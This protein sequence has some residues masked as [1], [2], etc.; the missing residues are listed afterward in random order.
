MSNFKSNLEEIDLQ[1]MY[2]PSSSTHITTFR[3]ILFQM[4]Q[5]N[6]TILT[7]LAKAALDNVSSLLE[8]GSVST[9]SL[10]DQVMASNMSLNETNGS[11]LGGPTNFIEELLQNTTAET[12]DTTIAWSWEDFGAGTRAPRS[13]ARVKTIADKFSEATNKYVIAPIIIFGII[14]N[15]FTLIVMQRKSFRTPPSLYFSVIAV[16]DTCVLI[17]YSL[18][19]YSEVLLNVTRTS[20]VVYC[21]IMIRLKRFFPNWSAWL[22]VAMSAQRLLTIV[23]P[24]KL[25]NWFTKRKTIAIILVITCVHVLLWFPSDYG[26]LATCKREPR[27]QALL[28]LGRQLD[29]YMYTNIP[30]PLLFIINGLLLFQVAKARRNRLKMTTSSKPISLSRTTT[31]T[32]LVSVVYLVLTFPLSFFHFDGMYGTGLRRRYVALGVVA[33]ISMILH[34]LNHAI[35]MILYLAMLPKFQTEVLAMIKQCF[36]C[37]SKRNVEDKDD[38]GKLSIPKTQEMSLGGSSTGSNAR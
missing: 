8:V 7:D 34:Y 24:L 13:R 21:T 32:V 36:S 27:N 30:T 14:S 5:D 19:E 28:N 16:A 23:F 38:T 6:T 26:V 22:I 3:C 15:C 33:E 1:R 37:L 25:S 18:K 10:A 4:F 12:F 35:N 29:Q 17:E 20:N 2:S 31:A 9:M 11:G